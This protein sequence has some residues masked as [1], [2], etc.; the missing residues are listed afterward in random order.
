MGSSKCL[1]CILHCT[2]S[3]YSSLR[4]HWMLSVS[5]ALREMRCMERF[6]NSIPKTVTAASRS[7]SFSSAPAAMALMIRADIYRE[8]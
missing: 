8:K 7:N 5:S 1:Y 2:F 4:F 3:R 6:K